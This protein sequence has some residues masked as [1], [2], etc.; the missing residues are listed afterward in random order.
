MR[1]DETAVLWKGKDWVPSLSSLLFLHFPPSCGVFRALRHCEHD[2]PVQWGRGRLAIDR[3]LSS[4]CIVYSEG[5]CLFPFSSIRYLSW[6]AHCLVSWNNESFGCTMQKKKKSFSVTT[7]ESW[8]VSLMSWCQLGIS[9]WKPSGPP[10]AWV[11]KA[12]D[13]AATTRVGSVGE[14]RLWTMP[15]TGA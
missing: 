12:R 1:M 10:E 5:K 7:V 8:S 9:T 6:Q 4:G 15:L 11:A 14:L 2:S 3:G 13:L